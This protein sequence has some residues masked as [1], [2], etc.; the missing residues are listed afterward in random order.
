MIV[1]IAECSATTALKGQIKSCLKLFPFLVRQSRVAEGC[2]CV[3]EPNKSQT[4]FAFFTQYDLY[5]ALSISEGGAIVS[6]LAN[7][8]FG[9]LRQG[10]EKHH[11]AY[12]HFTLHFHRGSEQQSPEGEN[13]TAG[14]R[15]PDRQSV[16]LIQDMG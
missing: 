7:P 10:S 12:A 2:G 8:A 16:P 13:L 11:M 5:Y 9:Q 1:F 15:W 6:G 3:G 14:N 4:P